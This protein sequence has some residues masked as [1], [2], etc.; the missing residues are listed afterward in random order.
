MIL[1]LEWRAAGSLRDTA[2]YH[3][4]VVTQHPN[5]SVGPA[6]ALS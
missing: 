2:V 5:D 3:E 1:M 4:G 6:K